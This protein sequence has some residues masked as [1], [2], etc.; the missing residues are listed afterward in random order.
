[1]VKRMA[2]AM[3]AVCFALLG[4]TGIDVKPAAAATYSVTFSGVV[5]CSSSAWGVQ[6]VWV[7]NANGSDD[8]ARW[9]AFPGK[10]NAAK[11]SITVT[12][13]RPDPAIRLDVGCGGDGQTWRKTLRTPDFRTRNGYTENRRCDVVAANGSR[14]C[15]PS[16][17][18]QSLSYNYYGPNRIGYG[19]CTDG[20]LRKW[21]GYTG[22]WPYLSGNA[23][24][25]D[26]NLR[27]HH[28][29]SVPMAASIVVFDTNANPGHVGWVTKVYKNANEKV[30]FDY[31][32]MN[33]GSGG[34][35]ANDWRTNEWNQ[36]HSNTGRLWEPG[37]QSFILAPT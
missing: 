27:G 14:S 31:V 7:Q 12:A 33:G 5:I 19:Y 34:S 25:M 16:P 13:N 21:H 10:P 28:K 23:G 37:K 26:D 2:A 17:R 11:Y 6:G 36:L 1:M 4:I 32:D 3:T 35:A 20:A 30:V 22:Y 9:W 29:S 15:V 24:Q 8:F 18:G